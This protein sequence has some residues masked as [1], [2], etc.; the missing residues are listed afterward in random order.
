M[1]PV[2]SRQNSDFKPVLIAGCLAMLAVGD[3]STAIM[4][5]LPDMKASLQLGFRTD[6]TSW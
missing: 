4:A 3:N 2:A 5:G 1:P 6:I